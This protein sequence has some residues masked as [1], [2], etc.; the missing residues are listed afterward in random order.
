MI[1]I[2]KEGC[3]P[4]AGGLGKGSLLELQFPRCLQSGGRVRRPRA[5]ARG[6]WVG[7]QSVGS[8]RPGFPVASWCLGA[9]VGILVSGQA[10]APGPLDTA[11][12]YRCEAFASA[13]QRA[14]AV[15]ISW[16]S[17]VYKMVDPV[18]LELFPPCSGSEG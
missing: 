8:P 14:E 1:L 10:F 13:S 3:W 5:P 2:C 17:S 4:T 15:C 7:L 9:E 6:S 18:R 11:P 12:I 16:C